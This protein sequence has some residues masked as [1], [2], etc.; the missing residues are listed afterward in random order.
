MSNISMTDRCD[1]GAT[2]GPLGMCVDYYHGILAEE[3]SDPQMYK[4]HGPVVMTYLLQHPSRA[5]EKYLDGQFRQ[6][7]LY[8]DQGLDAW[9]R[10]S[11]HQV[12]RNN[13]RARLGYDMTPLAAYASLPKGEPSGFR[14]SFSGLPFRDGSFVFD[15]HLAYGDHIKAIAEATVESWSSVQS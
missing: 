8:V 7:Q 12:A 1:C 15:G 3:Q 11:A 2:A 13:H 9:L 10:L 6:L 5:H 14:A 4:W